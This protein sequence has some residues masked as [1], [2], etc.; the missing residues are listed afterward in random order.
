[1]KDDILERGETTPTL[2]NSEMA[3]DPGNR[4]TKYQQAT[5][6]GCSSLSLFWNFSDFY[7]SIAS[8]TVY[9]F[10]QV[11]LTIRKSTASKR[12]ISPRAIS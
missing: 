6:A 10:Q 1:M 12:R 2:D 4:I 7:F 3:I 9:S 11:E 8:L 5:G